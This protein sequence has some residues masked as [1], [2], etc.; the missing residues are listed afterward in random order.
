MPIF[1]VS[2][3]KSGN[4]PD[5]FHVQQLKDIK[6]N[7]FTSKIDDGLSFKDHHELKEHLSTV[8]KIKAEDIYL[9]EI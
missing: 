4:N 9:L 3:K 2:K 6:G 7:D 8:L 5:V 1:E